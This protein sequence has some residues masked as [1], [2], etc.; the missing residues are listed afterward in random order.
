MEIPIWAN[1]FFNTGVIAAASTEKH[2][3]TL[4]LAIPSRS[5]AAALA[6][7]GIIVT[8]V[9]QYAERPS[10]SKHF[11][12]ICNLPDGAPVSLI[13]GNKI[14]KGVFDGCADH[15]GLK[16]ARIMV[17]QKNSGGGAHFIWEA[18]ALRVKVLPLGPAYLPK[19]QSGRPIPQVADF[20]RHILGDK[21]ALT[22]IKR[23]QLECLIVGRVNVLR[24]EIMETEF[25]VSSDRIVYHEGHL[26]DLLQ[27]HRFLNSSEPY[28]SDICRVNGQAPS[29][30]DNNGATPPFV[31]F[32][33]ATGF[34]RWRDQ[35]RSSNWIV[36]LDK[37]DARFREAT[38]VLNQAYLNRID[39][40]GLVDLPSPL[41][42]VDVMSFYEHSR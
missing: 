41:A 7:L 25:A 9:T 28:R 16:C 12:L 37:T 1:Y 31:I 30:V 38:E 27:V 22:F 21:Q 23:P 3:L 13:I 35:L 2:R 18:D 29:F 26:Q 4:C 14:K 34:I 8:R 17:E 10:P 11:E 6:A 19:R 20:A 15:H 39:D 36:I 40:N 24:R 32:D 33:G 42:G 5:Y